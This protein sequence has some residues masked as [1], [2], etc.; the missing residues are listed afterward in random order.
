M[1]LDTA[2]RY[3]DWTWPRMV[4]PRA[5]WPIGAG[6]GG[7]EE[8]RR[9]QSSAERHGGRTRQPGDIEAPAGANGTGA[10]WRKTRG[11]GPHPS[12]ARGVRDVDARR[13]VHVLDAKPGTRGG[14]RTEVGQL[15]HA[16]ASAH[17]PQ[18]V[19]SLSEDKQAT[20]P[21][22]GKTHRYGAVGPAAAVAAR[23]ENSSVWSIMAAL[24]RLGGVLCLLARRDSVLLI[25]YRLGP[26]ASPSACTVTFTNLH[27]SY[28]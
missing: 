8:T 2:T 5:C 17:P 15:G 28:R 10:W 1:S 7:W 6:R 26:S 14:A 4:C 13:V 21:R 19:R 27:N 22:Q 9:R 12:E 16:C 23:A 3:A 25:R 18:H 24:E 20:R 11:V